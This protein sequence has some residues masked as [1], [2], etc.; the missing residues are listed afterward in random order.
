MS[1]MRILSAAFVGIALIASGASAKSRRPVA[2]VL[3]AAPVLPAAVVAQIRP[4]IV[5]A[6]A[7]IRPIVVAARAADRPLTP[8]EIMV[9]R[10]VRS[11][12]RDSINDVLVGNNLPPLPERPNRPMNPRAN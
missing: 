2:A 1:K 6:I 8:S 9:I 4:I 7:E 12:T 10:D 5:E 11:D 3:P